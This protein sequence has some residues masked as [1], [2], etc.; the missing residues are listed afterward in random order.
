[1]HER[2]VF[3]RLAD[4]TR[5]TLTNHL[6]TD[7]VTELVAYHALDEVTEEMILRVGPV[8]ET[9]NAQAK[10]GLIDYTDMVYLPAFMQL[11]P[12]TT[13]NWLF[14]DE[15][16]DLNA[17][18]ADLVQKLLANGGRFIGVGDPKQSI[19]GFAGA[20][21][22]SFY[23]VQ[24]AFDAKEMPLSITYRCPKQVVKLA[25]KY[26]PHLQAADDAIEGVVRNIEGEGIIAAARIG[27]LILCR[28][29]APLIRECIEMIKLGIPAHVKDK[30]IG[31]SLVAIVKKVV[32]SGGGHFSLEALEEFRASAIAEIEPQKRP[33]AAIERLNDK[34]M[35]IQA[36]WVGWEARTDVA[37]FC[38]Y[39][40]SLF[41]DDKKGVTL[42]SIHKAKGLEKS[43][44]FV[45]EHDKLPCY[46]FATTEWQ[47]EQERNL[48][49]VAYTRPTHELVLV[50]K[51]REGISESARSL[52]VARR[53]RR[54]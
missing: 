6:D 34:I 31:G 10:E 23:E 11:S 50:S 36:C 29:N 8:I 16:Q 35:C 17:S 21:A 5:L 52:S 24:K 32:K 18:Q 4:L 20:A 12:P 38:K 44:V 25:Q 41:S 40:E 53:A 49:Y 33:E 48:V 2:S 39:I 19:Y 9:G 28:S 42:M 26:V 47:R 14:C 30:D 7:A 1:M 45:L 13:Y 43:R 54:R 46:F 37:T 15:L 22:N 3:V 27:D 51:R